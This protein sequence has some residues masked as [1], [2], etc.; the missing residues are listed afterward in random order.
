MCAPMW[1]Y[2]ET[3]IWVWDF[4]TL[5][6]EYMAVSN[7]F[8]QLKGACRN[9]SRWQLFPSFWGK[10]DLGLNARKP[11]FACEQ[12]RCRPAC[13]W[14]QSDQHLCYSLSGK[15]SSRPCFMQNFNILASFCSLADWFESYLVWNMEDRFFPVEAHLYFML[16][17]C[18]FNR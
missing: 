5:S 14:A 12:Q 10:W 6:S 9:C 17:I 1:D 2:F 13:A 15:Y 18:S 11:Y 7:L 3:T 4:Q 16:V 8:L